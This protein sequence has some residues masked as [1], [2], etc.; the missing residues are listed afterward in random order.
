MSTTTTNPA[1][2]HAGARTSI[3]GERSSQMSTEVE[4]FG[5]DYALRA[6]SDDELC[7][8]ELPVEVMYRE[9]I[10]RAH[11][12]AV[13]EVVAEYGDLLMLLSVPPCR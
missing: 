1:P 10:R 2:S 5:D 12:Q 8:A 9:M 13:D 3:E 6:L 7:A 11:A 4:R